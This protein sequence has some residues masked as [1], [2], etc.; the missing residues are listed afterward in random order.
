MARRP[1]R[2]T[3]RPRSVLVTCASSSAGAAPNCVTTT[4]MIGMSTFG[5]R[6]IGS[7]MKLIQPSISRMIDSTIDGSGLAD[8]PGR[9]VERHRVSA[10]A[11]E[12]P[13]ERIGL[14]WSPSRSEVPAM[15]HHHVAVGE[16]LADLGARVGHEADLDAPGLDL[17]VAHHLHARSLGA[18]EHGAARHRDAAR[19]R[20]VDGGAREGAD[21]QRRIGVDRN[22][23]AAELG[24]SVDVGRHQAQAPVEVAPVL[25][26]HAR[27]LPR[28]QLRHVD[29]RHLDFELD[30][31][32]RPRCGIAP[33]RVGSLA[34][35][36]R[37]APRSSA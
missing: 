22:A 11:V 17:A 33:R 30:L 6:V 20:R 2:P 36:L 35:R 21:A 24:Y 8:R 29:A 15:R 18:V 19:A 32:C 31:A 9:D 25:G 14:T 27:R 28:A 10:P 26:L 4:E 37:R 34:A 16:P 3:P 23:G 5:R 1:P 12:E 13:S 7:L